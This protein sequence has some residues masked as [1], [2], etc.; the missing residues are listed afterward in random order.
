MKTRIEKRD[1]SFTHD[2]SKLADSK[3]S[4]RPLDLSVPKLISNTDEAWQIH[5]FPGKGTCSKEGE[6]MVE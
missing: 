1:L 5:S 3:V 2:E 6:L 4:S